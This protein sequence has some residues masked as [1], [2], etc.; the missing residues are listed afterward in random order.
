MTNIH[1]DG[2]IEVSDKLAMSLWEAMPDMGKSGVAQMFFS[3]FVGAP[4]SEQ[5]VLAGVRVFFEREK[6]GAAGAKAVREAVQK[7][8]MEI[9]AESINQAQLQTII[10]D[11]QQKAAQVVAQ[12]KMREV[13]QQV[14]VQEFVSAAMPAVADVMRNLAVKYF[15]QYE[16]GKQ[17]VLRLI[18]EV[19]R[20]QAETMKDIFREQLRSAVEL[21]G[22]KSVADFMERNGNA[23]D[24]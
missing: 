5:A 23:L 18:E 8:C 14:P 3:R 10:R 13:F 1:F 21:N 4:I 12:E 19:K 17:W 11:E 6:L 20:E 7:K 9:G 22:R 16:E 15:T 2:P 24:G